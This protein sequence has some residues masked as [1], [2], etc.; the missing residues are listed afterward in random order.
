VLFAC[1]VIYTVRTARAGPSTGIIEPIPVVVRP[2]RTITRD[3]GFVVVGLL[4]LSIGARLAV[5]GAGAIGEAIGLSDAVIGSTIMAV[6]TSLPELVTCVIAAVKGHHDISVG[7]LVGSNIFNTLLVTGTAS[8][9]RPFS[10]GPQFAGGVDFWI[11]IAVSAGFTVALIAGRRTITRPW[12]AALLG[13]YVAYL[14]YLVL[15]MPPAP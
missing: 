11:M 1:L 9:V 12:G 14:V 3:T 7:N 8:T 10:V 5:I 13:S 6:G 15:S 4:G 2:P